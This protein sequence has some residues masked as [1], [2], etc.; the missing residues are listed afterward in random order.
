ME[1]EPWGQIEDEPWS[2]TM[3]CIACGYV[4]KMEG[5]SPANNKKIIYVKCP[6]C[7]RIEQIR[8]PTESW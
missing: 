6:Q 2:V 7:E 5:Y 8:N 1:N 4:G 3:D